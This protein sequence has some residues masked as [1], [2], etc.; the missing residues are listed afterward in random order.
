VKQ[1]TETKTKQQTKQTQI[2]TM[3]LLSMLSQNRL[4]QQ[5]PQAIPQLTQPFQPFQQ[6]QQMM[7]PVQ[8]QMAAQ[9]TPEKQSN[10]MISSDKPY[11]CDTCGRGYSY[12]AS[13]EQHK[14]THM[15]DHQHNCNGCG[16]LF[17]NKEELEAH[18]LTH[19]SDGNETR[20]HQ[21]ETCGRRFTLLENLHRH[22]M[23]HTDERPFGCH[24]CHKRF[25]LAQHLKE[26]IRIHTGE[27]PYKCNIC[28][29]AFCQISNLKS[30]QKTHT[31]VKAFECDICH[32]TFRRSFTLKQHKLIHERE[33]KTAPVS[34]QV[35]PAATITELKQEI[36]KESTFQPEDNFEVDVCALETDRMSP[37][38]ANSGCCGGHA[39]THAPA[40]AN[41][42][43]CGGH[44]HTHAPTTPP[45]FNAAAAVEQRKEQ[46]SPLSQGANSD[47]GHGSPNHS[48]SK[49][50]SATSEE[51]ATNS[52]S[53]DSGNIQKTQRFY[54][55]FEDSNVE[56]PI[57]TSAWSAAAAAVVGAKRPR[58]EEVDITQTK[59]MRD[60][61][62]K[63]VVYPGIRDT[64][65]RINPTSTLDE[66]RQTTMTGPHWESLRPDQE[67]LW[68]RLGRGQEATT[69]NTDSDMV[70][71][72][73]W[74]P[75]VV[76]Y[77]SLKD[78]SVTNRD[79]LSSQPS[80]Q[81]NTLKHP[82]F[83]NMVFPQMTQ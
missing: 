64:S 3:S 70:P 39:H 68:R 37:V 80:V 23:I 7:N 79:E 52:G 46:I 44:A 21:C 27:K 4:L 29:R 12:L 33:G 57:A 8:Q 10:N 78:G 18:K 16:R 5:N 74:R 48:S 35:T 47:S 38:T 54:R 51:E 66:L 75:I 2:T 62:G 81:P 43:C 45:T 60:N 22:Q 25:R 53:D 63:V 1:N 71:V 26:H 69:A 42:G 72:V 73:E 56:K 41:S 50:D 6:L 31:K 77:R 61:N 20:P 15:T 49:L 28:S 55:P 19:N 40:P 17:K 13:L 24:Y 58:V 30:H 65:A 32:K 82:F 9:A 14:A 34:A 76:G 59:R 36:K 83:P 11:V 67:F